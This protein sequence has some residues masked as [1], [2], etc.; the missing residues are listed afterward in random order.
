MDIDT[1]EPGVDF[2]E[3]IEKAVGSCDVLIALIGK[4]WLTITDP[5]GRRRLDNP[6]DFVRLE[7]KTALERN[8]RVIPA[9]I[10]GA[11]MPRSQDL[12]DELE[13]LTRRNAIEISD[14]RFRE[15]VDRLIRVLDVDRKHSVK[16]HTIAGYRSS[17]RTPSLF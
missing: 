2:V 1:I 12:P 5:A 17:A 8:I 15:D 9:L 4:Q 13:K 7:I 14:T 6:A 16:F 10:P 3:T 11:A